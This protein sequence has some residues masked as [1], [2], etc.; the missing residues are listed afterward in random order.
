[1]KWR[2]IFINMLALILFL[3]F[4]TPS[5]AQKLVYRVEYKDDSIGYLIAERKNVGSKTIYQLESRTNINM[6]FSFNHYAYYRSEYENDMLVDARTE[7]FLND[8]GNTTTSTT[9]E[10]GTY[11]IKKDKTTSKQSAPIYESIAALYFNR[12]RNSRIFSERHGS[13]FAISKVNER[14]FELIKPDNRRNIYYF[15]GDQCDKAT[16]NLPLATVYLVRISN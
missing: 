10:N 6:L 3:S 2:N 14:Q 4:I 9:Y 1:M 15:D 16:L 13:F 11:L 5:V 7:S 12:P 8:K